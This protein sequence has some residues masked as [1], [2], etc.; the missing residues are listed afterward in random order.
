MARLLVMVRQ[1]L[2]N[3]T[4]VSIGHSRDANS[5]AAA[6]AFAAAWRERG[7]HVSAVVDW[8][9]DAASWLRQARR[10]TAGTPDAWVIAAEVAGFVQLS[11]RLMHS[12]DWTARRTFAFGSL[13][14]PRC[15]ALAGVG[16]FEGLR[17]ATRDGKS[18]EVCGDGV[19]LGAD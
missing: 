3:G 15:G 13:A 6:N 1:G 19:V 9:E 2:R 5:A 8:P 14:D 17:G 16:V 7:C 18:W 12:T 11:R 4:T 10:L